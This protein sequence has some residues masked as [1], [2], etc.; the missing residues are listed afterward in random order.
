MEYLL[1]VVS[2]VAH[3]CALSTAAK[4]FQQTA[5]SALKD[6]LETQADLS[7]EHISVA[8]AGVT[9]LGECSESLLRDVPG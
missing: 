8:P 6:I 7:V 5:G 4:R 1:A 9:H 3:P 2:L